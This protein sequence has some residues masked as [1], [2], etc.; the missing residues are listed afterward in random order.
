MTSTT[1]GRTTRV[2]VLVAA[3]GIEQV[4]LTGPWKALEDA[5]W[6]P[7]LVSPEGG[8]VRAYNH[9]EAADSFP[10]DQRVAD[11]E[12]EDFAGL[13]LPGGVAN[14]DALRLDEGAVGLVRSFTAQGYPVA[15]ICHAIWM[16][17]EADVLGGRE[18]T[19][20]PSLQTDVRNAGG[21]WVDEEVVVDDRLV[22]SRKPDDIPAF[23]AAFLKVLSAG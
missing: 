19:S 3:E 20:W 10:V 18:V 11:V 8:E 17:V 2:A 6:D 21:T 16:L 13:L 12:V 9:L 4:E 1:N 15:A 14:P 22:T 5:G 23:S 7:V